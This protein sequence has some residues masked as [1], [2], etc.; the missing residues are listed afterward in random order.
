MAELF[1]I[2]DQL[3]PE[4]KFIIIMLECLPSVIFIQ[5]NLDCH[6]GENLV[7]LCHFCL[8][9]GMNFP[10]AGTLLDVCSLYN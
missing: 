8:L 5:Y 2:P 10:R 7:D 1:L 3:T 9:H 6:K 4:A